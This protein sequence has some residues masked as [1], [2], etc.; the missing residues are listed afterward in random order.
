M[1]LKVESLKKY[2]EKT[3]QQF[4]KESEPNLKAFLAR[5][6]KK[7]QGKISYLTLGVK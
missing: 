4:E 7:T 6:I 1:N 3:S 2:L 5:E